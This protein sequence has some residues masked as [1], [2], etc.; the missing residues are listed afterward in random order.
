MKTAI[1][2]LVSVLSSTVALA[3]NSIYGSRSGSGLGSSYG[4]GYGTG[5]NP[6]SHYV[7]PRYNLQ[8]GTVSSGHYQTNPN[9][10]Q[11]DNFGTRG[12]Y[13]PYSGSYGTRSPKY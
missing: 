7:A 4:G 10:T 13:N 12:N 2:L 5:S 6:N 1:I 9:N 11:L 8:S 3:Q